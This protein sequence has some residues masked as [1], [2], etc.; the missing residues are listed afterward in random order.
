MADNQTQGT[1][2]A[3]LFS[4]LNNYESNAVTFNVAQE[5]PLGTSIEYF[6]RT[7]WDPSDESEWHAIQPGQTLREGIK[8]GSRLQV[9]AVLKGDGKQTPIL[10]DWNWQI[11]NIT[12]WSGHLFGVHLVDYVWNIGTEANA[13]YTIKVTWDDDVNG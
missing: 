11:T 12:A 5:V 9:K 10:H 2:Q 7:Q 6:Y 4:N 13:N 8:E 1:I 3:T